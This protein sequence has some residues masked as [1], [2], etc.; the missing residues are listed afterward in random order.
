[1]GRLSL[2]DIGQPTVVG[3]LY[4]IKQKQKK[5]KRSQYVKDKAKVKARRKADENSLQVSCQARLDKGPRGAKS[6]VQE[7]LDRQQ[8]RVSRLL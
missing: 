4:G 8:L 1:M 7:P 3:H 5:N 2:S 6:H